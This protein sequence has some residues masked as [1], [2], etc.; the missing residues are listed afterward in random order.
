M[1][2]TI[3]TNVIFQG[4]YSN[5]GASYQILLLLKDGRIKLALSVPVFLEYCDVLK[6]QST[7]EKTGLSATQI[8]SVLD[9]IAFA[10]LE[11]RISFLYR[12]NLEDESDNKFVELALASQSR[13]LITANIKHFTANHELSLFEVKV[14]TP[15]KFLTL[16]R[17]KNE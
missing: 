12:P 5:V 3:D 8:N 16:W 4:L 6:R 17:M 14:V 2:V 13:Y 7:L 9:F 15:G 10:G 11:H 1:I